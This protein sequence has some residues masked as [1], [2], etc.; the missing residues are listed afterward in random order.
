MSEVNAGPFQ[1][2]GLKVIRSYLRDY[3]QNLMEIPGKENDIATGFAIGIFIS[4]SP[5][6][7]LHIILIF[8]VTRLFKK[9]FGAGVLASLV[10]NPITAPFLWTI[11][12]RVGKLVMSIFNGYN[13][14]SLKISFTEFSVL[15]DNIVTAFYPIFFGGLVLGVPASLLS[16]FLVQRSLRLYRKRVYGKVSERLKARQEKKS[17]K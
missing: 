1:T 15:W 3:Y 6:I 2:G 12:Y 5:W 7:G 17:R 11:E 13:A 14:P 4:F 16:Y 9:S 8:L 10:F